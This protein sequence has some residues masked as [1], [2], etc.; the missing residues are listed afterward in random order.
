MAEKVILPPNVPL[1]ADGSKVGGWWHK[2]DKRDRVV[3]D[4]CPRHCSLKEGARGFCFVR[5]NRGGQIVLTTYGRSTGFCID[6]IE[7]KPLNQFYPGSAVLSFGTGGC[8]LGCK[9]CQNWTTTKSQQ[10]DLWCEEASPEAIAEAAL[11][12]GCTSVAFTY[13]EPIIW[14]EYA[15]DT[16]EACRRLGIKTVAVTNGYIE[17]EAR[18]PFFDLMDAAN[19]DLKGFTEEFYRKYC[20][21][22]LQ[23]VLD[24]LKWLVHESSVWVEITNLLI[25]GANDSPDEI[26]AM[27]RWIR[28]ELRP[29]VPLHFTAFHPDFQM[30]DHPPT[31]ARTLLMAYDIARQEGLHYVYTGN[32][33]DPRTQATYCPGCGKAVIE[34][35]GYHIGGYHLRGNR[36]AFC[37][38]VIAGHYADEVGAW[39]GRRQPIRIPRRPRS[40]P[41]QRPST[42]SSH[43]G[44]A[45]VASAAATSRTSDRSNDSLSATKEK[46]GN[47]SSSD[48]SSEMKEAGT[49][50]PGGSTGPGAKDSGSSHCGASEPWPSGNPGTQGCGTAPPAGPRAFGNP[51]SAVVP[52]RPRLSAEEESKLLRVAAERVAAAVCGGTLPTAAGVL[53]AAGQLPVYG[54]FVSL[55]RHGQL[56]SCCG[57]LGEPISLAMAVDQAAYRAAKEDYR[58]PPI[59]PAELKYLDIEVWVLWNYRPMS[60]RGEARANE[61]EIG[62]HGLLVARGP[63]RGLLLPGVAVEYALDPVS[64]LEHTCLKAGLPA[65]AWK[66][67]DVQVYTFEGYALHGRLA[68]LV[69]PLPEDTLLPGPTDHELHQLAAVVRQNVWALLTGATP[70]FYHPQLFDGQ[71]CGLVLWAELPGW[72]EPVQELRLHL[73]PDVPLQ[74][75]LYDLTQALS[76]ALL[77]RQLTPTVFPQLRVDVAV[78]WDVLP[79]RTV[80][81]PDWAGFDSGRRAMMVIAEN[82]WGLAYS[83]GRAPDQILATVMHG[84]PLRRPQEAFVYSFRVASTRKE[85]EIRRQPERQVTTVR[86][87]VVAGRFYPA[88][89][90]SITSQLSSWATRPVV[91]ENW[92]GALVPH[93]G[94][95]YSGRLAFETL[96]HVEIPGTVLIFATKHRPEGASW[97]VAPYERWLLPDGEVSGDVRLAKKLAEEVAGLALDAAAHA[98][99]HAVEVILPM[100]RFLKPDV[101]VVAIVMRGGDIEEL[102][103]FGAQA[104]AVL[105]KEA[106]IPLIVISTDFSH[107]VPEDEARRL[108]KLAIEAMERCQPEELFEIVRQKQISICGL[109]PTVAALFTLR[110]LGRLS[111]CYR[112]AYTTSGEVSGDRRAVVGYAGLLFR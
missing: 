21:G 107:Y 19:V 59:S 39:G 2:D 105:S 53:G 95:M 86:Q 93:A 52:E 24:T 94:W 89:A 71:V 90:E 28:E 70:T 77:A 3:C 68:E 37:E 63:A 56:R 43:P 83:P 30:L 57:A 8:N 16:A 42:Q 76:R 102:E 51:K 36:C 85:W 61:V 66:A 103:S 22:H 10:T 27:C 25:P 65:Q 108:D 9:F 111:E 32:I 104:A 80:A 109:I 84:L 47:G 81:G 72:K 45:E 88:T 91:P 6:P 92:A 55:K 11:A 13:N 5:Q 1:L 46:G 41:P 44:C 20:L 110:S 60:S 49:G 33:L 54:V 78:L 106:T 58:F 101:R 31:P 18:K 38:T 7:K 67:E 12:H 15:M 75:T 97:A 26:R 50:T 69:S 29:D 74:S 99:E 64:F 87:P 98:Q 34:R 96:R 4:L 35:Q 40:N 23:P 62:R 100:L 73:R 112:V 48:G 14:A 82:A 17:S 79:H